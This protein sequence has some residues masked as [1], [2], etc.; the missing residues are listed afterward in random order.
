[1]VS[2]FANKSTAQKSQPD[3]ILLKN[4]DILT[5]KV[6]LSDSLK[7]KI[8][9]ADGSENGFFIMKTKLF[10]LTQIFAESL[11]F[12]GESRSQIRIFDIAGRLVQHENW[13]FSNAGDRQFSLKNLPSG[14]YFLKKIEST[15]QIFFG[16]F[17]VR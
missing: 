8:R 13:E 10:S 17:I 2:I 9:R 11:G 4:G 3:K 16:K 5:G 1:M 7:L 14:I 6:N 12:S 15:G